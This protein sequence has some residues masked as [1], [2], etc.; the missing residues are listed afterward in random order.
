MPALS[1]EVLAGRHAIL[2]QETAK[3]SRAVSYLRPITVA[4]IGPAVRQARTAPF[5]SF[6]SSRSF[7][8]YEPIILNGCS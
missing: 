1:F 3:K 5:E 7:G 8:K 2:S 4:G 6:I